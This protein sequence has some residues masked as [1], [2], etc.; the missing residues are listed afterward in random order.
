MS[1][2]AMQAYYARDRE[3]DRLA[4]GV[5]R[6]EFLRTVEVVERTLP[7]PPATVAD[8]GGGPGR[9]TDWLVERG[10]RVIHRDI[11]EQHVQHVRHRHGG[12]VDAAVGDARQ[13]DLP[14]DSADAVLLLGPLYH[15]PERSDR[16]VALTEAARIVR[17]G[18]PI[19]VAVISRWVSR[20]QGIV[21]LRLYEQ[22]PQVLDAIDEVERTGVMLPIIDSGFTG[23]YHTVEEIRDEITA[24]GLA[25]E[26]LVGLEGMSYALADLDDRLADERDREILLTALRV[27]EAVPEML[28]VSPHLL[29]NCR[30][31]G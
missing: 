17:G 9:Y 28:G 4:T 11:V 23:Y 19:H 26:S 18:G 25:L 5:G 1:D 10:Y 20:M 27:T 13:L 30:S 8:I 29:A 24:A 3:R 21:A 22:Y 14:D 15:L 12:A 7:A 2:A 16:E 31:T 6:V